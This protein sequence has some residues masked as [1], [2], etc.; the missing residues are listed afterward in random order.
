M[1]RRTALIVAVPEAA[2]YYDMGNGVPAHVTILFPFAPPHEVDED[3]LEAVLAPFAPFAFTLDRIERWEA[4][5]VL[6]RSPD[7]FIALTRA[8]WSRWP[9]FPPYGGKHRTVVPHLTTTRDGI[10]LPLTARCSD[11]RLIEEDDR[12]SWRT[13]RTFAL[14]GVA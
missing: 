13:R 14:Q 10:P 4:A 6:P 12:G 2:A 9:A 8:V 5:V 1:P 11:V 7:P 3:A